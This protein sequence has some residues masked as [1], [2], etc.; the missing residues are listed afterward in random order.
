MQLEQCNW[1]IA[2][3]TVQLERA[4]VKRLTLTQETKQ[5]Q[6]KIEYA[7]NRRILQVYVFKISATSLIVTFHLLDTY[8]VS[9]SLFPTAK[10]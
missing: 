2:T 5:I 7:P 8:E 1:N 3:G 4:I 9:M 10:N 6:I